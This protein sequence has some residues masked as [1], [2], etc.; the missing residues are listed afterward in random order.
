MFKKAPP[1]T[2]IKKEAKKSALNCKNEGI[3]LSFFMKNDQNRNIMPAEIYLILESKTGGK[4]S[5][6]NF[7]L[8]YTT[9]HVEYNAT[10]QNIVKANFLFLISAIKHRITIF[11]C[12]FTDYYY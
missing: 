5:R 2:I 1:M 3:A 6:A 4:D 12:Y 10:R 7:M 11:Y 8:K 9:P